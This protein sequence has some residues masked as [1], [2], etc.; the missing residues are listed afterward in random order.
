MDNKHLHDMDVAVDFYE[1][2]YLDGYMEEWD[3]NKKSKVREVIK[4]L[5]LPATGKALDFGCG[6][7]VFTIILKECLPGWDIYGVE[8]SPTAVQQASSK[9]PQCT[10]FG[11][12][13]AGNF[14]NQFDFLFS[15]H[16]IEH[17]QDL[18]ETFSII[19]S[20]L[21]PV[22]SQLHILP[23]GNEGSYE[24][25]IVSLKK[26]GIERDNGNRFFFEESGHLQRLTTR[27]FENFEKEIGF[28]LVRD[29]Y[30][31]QFYGA[32]N[33]ITKTSPTFLK[34]LTS[35]SDAINSNAATELNKLKSFLLP[36][37]Y[38]Q[39]AYSKYWGIKSKWIKKG[40]DYVKMA[41][42]FIPA[43]FSYPVYRYYEKKAL[44][45]WRE[46]NTERNG[47]EMFLFFKRG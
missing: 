14:K 32:V 21:K 18:R 15:H 2:R 44:Q 8:I 20:Y 43:M 46:R 28:T 35:T 39:F 27:E 37:L 42:L 25:N 40:T 29:F 22:S 1:Q 10:F 3:D 26:N 7:G 41:A 36:R 47:S 31:N 4:G 30:S 5:G 38:L 11:I 19:N 6:N 17:V 9:F 23:C 13:Q 16:V 24:Y 45:E 33:W 12:D 34:K